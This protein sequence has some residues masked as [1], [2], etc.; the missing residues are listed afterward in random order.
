V[1][2]AGT[3]VAGPVWGWKVRHDRNINYAV[4]QHAT[5]LIIA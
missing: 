3:L 4:A 2:L 1:V 5:F